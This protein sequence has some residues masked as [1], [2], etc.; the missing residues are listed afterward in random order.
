[1]NIIRTKLGKGGRVI[2]PSSVRKHLNIN[3]GDDILLHLEDH[4]IY[5]TTPNQALYKLQAKVKN[6]TQT[7]QQ[8]TNTELLEHE[9]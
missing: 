2:L 5:I 4:M 7:N 1:M 3:I 8:D 6:Y 9:N